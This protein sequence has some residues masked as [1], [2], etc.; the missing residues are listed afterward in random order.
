MLRILTDRGSEYKGKY[1]H[2]EYELYLTIEGIEHSKTHV[3]SPQSDGICE[4]L[5]RTIKEEFYIVAFRK[6]LYTTPEQLQCDLDE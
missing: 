4:R 5:N 3:R 1:E 2:H 6:W